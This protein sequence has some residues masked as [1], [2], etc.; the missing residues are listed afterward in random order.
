LSSKVGILPASVYHREHS[1]TKTW[2]INFRYGGSLRLL[3]DGHYRELAR[4]RDKGFRKGAFKFKGLWVHSFIL[5]ALTKMAQRAG[6][7]SGKLR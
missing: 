7:L 6:Y 5:L 4:R 2:R 1:L 3:K